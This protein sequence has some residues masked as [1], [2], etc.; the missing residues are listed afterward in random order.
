MIKWVIIGVIVIAVVALLCYHILPVVSA[1]RGIF[2]R[3]TEQQDKPEQ[4]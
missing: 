2:A 1:V 4:G 3:E